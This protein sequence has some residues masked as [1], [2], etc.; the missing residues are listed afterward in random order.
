VGE[1]ESVHAIAPAVLA[2]PEV[3][4]VPVSDMYVCPAVALVKTY[5]SS[6]FALLGE[7][8]N[9]ADDVFE[10]APFSQR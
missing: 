5:V 10:H 1:L 7:L 2:V 3:K 4:E 8:P 6:I 9:P